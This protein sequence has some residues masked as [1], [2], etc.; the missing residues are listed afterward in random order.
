MGVR[1]AEL[2]PVGGL[3][4]AGLSLPFVQH[5]GGAIFAEAFVTR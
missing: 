2:G 4:S 1:A 3:M 5:V